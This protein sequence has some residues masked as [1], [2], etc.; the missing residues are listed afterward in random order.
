LVEK[1]KVERFKKA[2]YTVKMLNHSAQK[3]GQTR[4]LVSLAL[5]RR[6]KSRGTRQTRVAGWPGAKLFLYDFS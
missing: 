1:V 2:K 6:E 3:K 4:A 5:S